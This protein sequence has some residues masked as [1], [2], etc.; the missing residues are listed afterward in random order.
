MGAAAC[1]DARGAAPSRS[2]AALYNRRLTDDNREPT[3][4]RTYGILMTALRDQLSEDEIESLT[5]EGAQLS[6]DEA[7]AEAMAV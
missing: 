4:Q 7:V 1:R 2:F 5:A 3:E 6:E